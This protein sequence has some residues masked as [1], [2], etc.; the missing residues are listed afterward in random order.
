MA[1]EAENADLKIK[2]ANCTCGASGAALSPTGQPIL[3]KIPSKTG[4]INEVT[5]ANSEKLRKITRKLSTIM[6]FTEFL[7]GQG[8]PVDK[9]EE[10]A[11]SPVVIQT[12]LEQAKILGNP[13]AHASKTQAQDIIAKWKTRFADLYENNPA[14]LQEI[15]EQLRKDINTLA[16]QNEQLN[17]EKRE[18]KEKIDEIN[19]QLEE[20]KQ[21][22]IQQK[23][24]V[25][26]AYNITISLPE[27]DHD[28][29]PVAYPTAQPNGLFYNNPYYK[30]GDEIPVVQKRS[31]LQTFLIVMICL[32]LLVLGFCGGFV[33][34][35]FKLVLPIQP[36]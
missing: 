27:E 21:L 34:G 4:P 19:R 29:I 9:M 1:L 15:D 24:E 36:A 35:Q 31:H 12:A 25:A 3:P 30:I 6:G 26:Q 2:L 16:F 33:F 32:I 28:I 17:R 5:R 8:K 10:E 13:D 18:N 14:D 23:P 11:S 20:T 22:L 7:K